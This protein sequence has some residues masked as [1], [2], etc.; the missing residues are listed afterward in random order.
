ML[1]YILNGP[2]LEPLTLVEAKR[3]LRIDH[4]DD[5]ALVQSLVKAARQRVEARTG[6][7]LISQNWRIVMD[8][9]PWGGRVALPVMPA[10]AVTAVRVFDGFG[11]AQTFT[12][13]VYRLVPGTE[14]PVLDASAVPA[15]GKARDGIEIDVTAGYGP[16]AADV[17]EPLRQAMRLMIAHAYGAVGPDGRKTSGPEPAEINALLAPYRLGRVAA[18]LTRVPA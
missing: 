3:L 14:P 17:P 6:R 9:W 5:D 15:P 10:Q 2:A 4:A 11:V 18:A 1:R 16:A 13:P 8:A 12:V 7:A